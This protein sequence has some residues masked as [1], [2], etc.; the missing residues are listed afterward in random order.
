MHDNL[1][2]YFKFKLSLSQHGF[3]KFKYTITHLASYL[4]YISPLVGS[5]RQVEVIHFDMSSTFDV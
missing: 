1:T 5:G 3:F 2:Y 4:Y